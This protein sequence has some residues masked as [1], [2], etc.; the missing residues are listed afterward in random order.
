MFDRPY[1]PPADNGLLVL[2]QD[3]HLIAVDKPSG[4]LSVPGRGEDKQDC[5]IA[6]V[7]LDFS[8]ALIVHRLDMETSGI[9]LLARSKEAHRRLSIAFQQRQVDKQYVA[10]VDGR[11]AD[12]VGEVDLPLICDWPNRPRQKVDYEY[13]KPSLTRYQQLSYDA[14]LD[15]TRVLLMPVTGRSHQLRVHMLSLNHVIL[16]DPLYATHSALEKSPRLL[17]H[18]SKLALQHPF[19]E[20]QLVINS[21]APF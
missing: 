2:Y 16:G 8:D 1:L 10:V 15:A 21:E 13:G 12:A 11:V 7:Q 18:A 14:S 4:L 17:L 5:M 20:Q 6:R 3:E 19:T 9:L